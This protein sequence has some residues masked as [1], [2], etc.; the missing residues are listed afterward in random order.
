MTIDVGVLVL[1]TDGLQSIRS[2]VGRYLWNIL[3][4]GERLQ[5]EFRGRGMTVSFSAA[6]PGTNSSD[7]LLDPARFERAQRRLRDLGGR[8]FRL[9]D[10]A[11]GSADPEFSDY[12]HIALA[13]SAAQVALDLAQRHDALLVV[14]GDHRFALVPG[15]LLRAARQL[16]L[17]VLY[18]H[19]TH[20]PVPG[21]TQP[22]RSANEQVARLARSEPRLKIG[23][24]S[25]YM[26]DRYRS[27]YGVE[28]HS[29]LA[30]ISGIPPSV[31]EIVPAPRA[32]ELLLE[33]GIPVDRPLMLTWG[34]SDPVKGFDT[35]LRAS[36]LSTSDA[37]LVV[38]NPV[39][40]PYLLDLARDEGIEALFITA[41]PFRLI[42]AIL[43][44][45]LT[46][47][48]VFASRDEPAAVAPVEAMLLGGLGSCVVVAPPTAC[49]TEMIDDGRTGFLST[50]RSPE[51]LAQAMDR[52]MAQPAPQAR[53]VASA[54]RRYVLSERMFRANFERTLGEALQILVPGSHHGHAL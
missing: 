40:Y 26:R 39:P 8:A 20:S 12:D 24:E 28:E 19:M 30:A 54:A 36:A 33:A 10:R 1:A 11:A 2:G 17:D 50:E 27:F 51:S 21:E 31:D 38:C 13:A 53:S 41:G 48:A 3:N 23:F 9:V 29:F 43:Q 34:R 47:A 44:W 16:G 5:D 6:E 37:L 14:G 22:E 45:P 4:D 25:H 35:V 15:L 7:G 46:R 42:S 18:V 32:R 49:Y 52:A